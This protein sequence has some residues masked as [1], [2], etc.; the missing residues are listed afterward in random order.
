M[1][2][3]TILQAEIHAIEICMRENLKRVYRGNEILIFFGSQ[4]KTKALTCYRI[5]S[6]FIWNHLEFLLTLANQFKVTLG[7]MPGDRVDS[8]NA[9]ADSLAKRGSCKL[10]KDSESVFGMIV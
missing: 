5:N 1:V 4:I 8:S 2:N 7:W 9:K 10:F 3:A 6:K